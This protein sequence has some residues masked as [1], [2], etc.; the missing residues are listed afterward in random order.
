M[1]LSE[2]YGSMVI[3]NQQPAYSLNKSVK[4]IKNGLSIKLLLV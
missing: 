4:Y 2:F 3:R 1:T